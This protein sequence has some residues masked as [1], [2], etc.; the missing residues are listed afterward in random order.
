VP[1]VDSWLR[2]PF[3]LRELRTWLERSA[4][5]APAIAGVL[6]GLAMGSYEMLA[7]WSAG[8][9][10]LEPLRIIGA[11]HPDQNPVLAGLLMHIATSAFWGTQL[12][13]V[14]R[15]APPWLLRSPVV[16][17][18]GIL[19]GAIVW[20]LMGE[21][22]GPLFSHRLAEA[23]PVHFFVGHLLYGLAS[24]AAL[25]A[26]LAQQPERSDRDDRAQTS[27]RVPIDA[28]PSATST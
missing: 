9:S 28:R 22:I 25:G 8:G 1:A 21:V 5:L 10:P 19:W 17:V 15:S 26:Y 7:T 24:V 11:E 6:G 4:G 14:L 13:R 20:A 12:G 16:A 2:E 3:D 27:Q 18:V 23:D